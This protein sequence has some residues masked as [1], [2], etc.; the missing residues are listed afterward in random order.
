MT[1]GQPYLAL[2]KKGYR[3]VA[4]FYHQSFDPIPLQSEEVRTRPCPAFERAETRA[5]ATSQS[6]NYFIPLPND[7]PNIP[8]LS[9]LIMFLLFYIH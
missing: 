8:S 1:F 9:L 7:R 6:I 4:F 5:I 2:P 3:L